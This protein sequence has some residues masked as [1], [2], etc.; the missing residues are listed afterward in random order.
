MERL[1]LQEVWLPGWARVGGAF[2]QNSTKKEVFPVMA[3]LVVV[4]VVLG[5]LVGFFGSMIFVKGLV[6]EKIAVFFIFLL[7]ECWE[8]RWGV[9][10]FMLGLYFLPS[11]V[12]II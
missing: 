1:S 7:Q 3:R 4:G 6:G 5:G 2:C 12:G 9:P 11:Y 8:E 10:L